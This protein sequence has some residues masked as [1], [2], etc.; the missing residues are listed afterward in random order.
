MDVKK[1]DLIY[2]FSLGKM[3]AENKS[4]I[5][6]SVKGKYKEIINKEEALEFSSVS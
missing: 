2:I 3:E 1:D 5:D 4:I 6:I